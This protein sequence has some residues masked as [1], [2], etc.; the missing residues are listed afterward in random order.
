MTKYYKEK[1]VD[2]MHELP[3]LFIQHHRIVQDPDYAELN[4]DWNKYIEL[5]KLGLL[6]ILT[7]RDGTT[8]VGYFF[9]V[10]MPH[11]LYSNIL[12]GF[13]DLYF[14]LPKYRKGF[15]GI[16]LIRENSKMLKALGAKKQ[17][18]S[19]NA[20]YAKIA[21]ILIYLGFTPYETSFTKRL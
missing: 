16:S 17:V 6:H 12:H 15:A 10:C 14:L 13:N 19:V 5:E 11:I 21:K 18:L 9:N 4:I 8:L 7:V 3:A 2:I 20:G 1:F